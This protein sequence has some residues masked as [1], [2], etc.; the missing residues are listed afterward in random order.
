M[1]AEQAER[2][3]VEAE[4]RAERE[5]KE[6]AERAEREKQAA[7]EEERRGRKKPPAFA[8]KPKPKKPRASLNSNALQPKKRPA[9][10][11]LNTAALSTAVISQLVEQ[12]VPEEFAKAALVAIASGKIQDAIIRY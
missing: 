5:K 12:G 7:I 8:V 6:A 2:A 9:L 1:Q 11:M 3:R 10:R 4:Q